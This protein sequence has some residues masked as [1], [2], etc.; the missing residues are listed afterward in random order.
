MR[1]D[2]DDDLRST[3]LWI[4]A[5]NIFWPPHNDDDRTVFTVV[6]AECYG[7]CRHRCSGSAF[8][9]RLTIFFRSAELNQFFGCWLSLLFFLF[10]ALGKWTR[11]KKSRSSEFTDILDCFYFTLYLHILYQETWGTLILGGNEWSKKFDRI[12]IYNL[13][14]S[15]RQGII[16]QTCA[17]RMC[18]YAVEIL[19]ES[20]E[21]FKL[22]N[23][24]GALVPCAKRWWTLGCLVKKKCERVLKLY[25]WRLLESTFV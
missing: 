23:C 3:L 21:R 13:S 19:S 10:H 24:F 22:A 8:F 5:T 17:W 4:L 7:H 16:S 9:A 2:F 15:I 11:M 14:S 1:A 6:Q 20:S 12:G 18:T 25:F